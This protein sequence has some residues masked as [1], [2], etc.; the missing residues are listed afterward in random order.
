MVTLPCRS[1]KSTVPWKV[2]ASPKN[3][4]GARCAITF[5]TLH[6]RGAQNANAK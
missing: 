5:A 6:L 3:E 2:P 1:D 4:G